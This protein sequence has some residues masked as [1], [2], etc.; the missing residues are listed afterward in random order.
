MAEI[1]GC[2]VAGTQVTGQLCSIINELKMIRR[3]FDRA[4]REIQEL[5]EEIQFLGQILTEV[6]TTCGL[7]PLSHTQSNVLP[8]TQIVKHCQDAME[9]LSDMVNDLNRRLEQPRG[10]KRRL[11]TFKVVW[12]A[13]EVEHLEKRLVRSLRILQICIQS[14]LL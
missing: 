8:L 7:D 1:V 10:F 2:L 4:P 14:I 6:E 12:K 13:K 9:A 11:A 5:M 3:Q